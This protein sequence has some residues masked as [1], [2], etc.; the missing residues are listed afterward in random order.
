L[1][2]FGLAGLV[3]AALVTTLPAE[4]ASAPT[5]A[6]ASVAAFLLPRARAWRA[7]HVTGRALLVGLG[8]L[9]AGATITVA[10]LDALPGRAQSTVLYRAPFAGNTIAVA[11]SLTDADGDGYSPILLGGDC[12]D[13]DAAVHPGARDIPENGIDENC[14]G[15]DATI[16]RPVPAPD[17]ARPPDIPSR[18]NIV[19]L[20]LDALRPDRLGFAG[21]A[22]PTSPRIDAFRET[23]TWF[24]NAY[25]NAPSTRFAMTSVFTGYDARRVPHRDLGGNRFQLEPGATTVAELLGPHGYDTVGYTISYVMHHN[26]GLGQGFRVWTTPWPV[27]DWLASY[28]VAAERT[29]DAALA[30]LAETPADGSRPY[31]LFGHYRCTHDP[32]IP[33]EEWHYGNSPSDVYDGTINYCDVHIGR[34]LD[35]LESR[36]DYDRTVVV[37]FSDHGEL[38]GEHGLT[39]HGNSLYEPDVRVLML[40]R[41]PF[42]DARTVETPVALADIAPTVLDLA[43][44]PPLRD[45]D[46][47][48]LLTHVS[49]DA[50]T[51]P[52]SRPLFMFTDIW[53]AN[54][55]I[56]ERAVL[57]W[58]MK[59]IRDVRTG[60][61]RL[62]DVVADPAEEDDLASETNLG[63]AEL[64]ELLDAHEAFIESTR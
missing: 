7:R 48:S 57:R 63:H 40:A 44:L 5:L 64:S 45:A 18:P 58:P 12:N 55:H 6:L 59:Y 46:G 50:P 33:Y 2:L 23:A 51:D 24:E 19:L 30:Y 47:W 15:S 61:A 38:F 52:A 14:S 21:Y 22:R 32:Y 62:Y 53:R 31:F 10:S 34:L 35:A 36:A 9:A 28:P 8:V 39:N 13:A 29:T 11:W 16:Y 20:Q 3:A 49:P 25:T 42:G 4:Y 27:D 1:V 26:L 54:V 41:F 60:S 37:L 56:E 43:G 17:V